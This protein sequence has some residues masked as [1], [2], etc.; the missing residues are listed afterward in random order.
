MVYCKRGKGHTDSCAI[1]EQLTSHKW[2]KLIVEEDNNTAAFIVV[3]N[4]G[5]IINCR[6]T[7][8]NFMLKASGLFARRD[9]EYPMPLKV[10][11][12]T[13]WIADLRLGVLPHQKISFTFDDLISTHRLWN[14]ADSERPL[15]I[16][17]D[18]DWYQSDLA[19]LVLDSLGDLLVSLAAYSEDTFTDEWRMLGQEIP[20]RAAGQAH[21][22]V[23]KNARDKLAHALL[24]KLSMTEAEGQTSR[25]TTGYDVFPD[26]T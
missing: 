24:R 26:T 23:F 15:G 3:E 18:D 17:I 9:H 2:S 20:N 13:R 16:W 1:F 11:L 12:F 21:L 25:R 22:A 10:A 8:A 14:N 19:T 5:C 6:N 4:R 7:C